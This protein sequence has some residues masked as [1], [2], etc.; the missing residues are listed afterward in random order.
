MALFFGQPFPKPGR[1]VFTLLCASVWFRT[2]FSVFPLILFQFYEN[3]DGSRDGRKKMGTK[4]ER[5]LSQSQETLNERSDR[6][7]ANWL[8]FNFEE[9]SY[10]NLWNWNA[11]RQL[12]EF[13][14]KDYFSSRW[15]LQLHNIF[16]YFEYAFKCI[17]IFLC[18]SLISHFKL[19]RDTTRGRTESPRLLESSLRLWHFMISDH[20]HRMHAPC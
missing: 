9:P 20:L 8:S 11:E 19:K 17:N 16:I 1:N 15:R 4:E 10:P 12:G 2:A 7:R 6:T 14:K 18:G 3:S 5:R 13:S